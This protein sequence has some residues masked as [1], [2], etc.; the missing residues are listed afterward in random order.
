MSKIEHEFMKFKQQRDLKD[1]SLQITC[2]FLNGG[3]Y[4]E[5]LSIKIAEMSAK[6]MSVIEDS[7]L[8]VRH[9]QIQGYPNSTKAKA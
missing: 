2:M 3:V 8:L 7:P 4:T 1:L 6:V 9:S 5:E